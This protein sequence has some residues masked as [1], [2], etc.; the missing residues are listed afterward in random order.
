MGNF[1][2]NLIFDFL[3]PKPQLTLNVVGVLVCLVAV[4]LNFLSG[5]IATMTLMIGCTIINAAC[6]SFN[7]WRLKEEGED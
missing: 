4:Y 2:A 7:Y 3:K 5:N 6:A 1:F